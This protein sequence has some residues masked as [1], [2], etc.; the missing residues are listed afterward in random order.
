M[1]C[2]TAQRLV[3]LLRILERGPAGPLGALGDDAVLDAWFGSRS[4]RFR[5]TDDA[6]R[7]GDAE[8]LATSASA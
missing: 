2:E 6:G 4:P 8:H 7:P 1:M 5:S 3:A